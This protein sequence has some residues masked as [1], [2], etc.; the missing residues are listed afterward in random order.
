[1]S[2]KKG[3][4]YAREEYEDSYQIVKRCALTWTVK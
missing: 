3:K 2:T 1:M 4:Y